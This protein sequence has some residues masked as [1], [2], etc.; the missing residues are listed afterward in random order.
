MT[1]LI[2]KARMLAVVARKATPPSWQDIRDSERDREAYIYAAPEI[3]A[4]LEE[5]A[6]RLECYEKESR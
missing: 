3:T 1:D 4:T 5:M 2:E 6:D